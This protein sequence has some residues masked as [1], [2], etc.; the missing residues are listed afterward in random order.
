MTHIGPV[1]PNSCQASSRS[2]LGGLLTELSNSPQLFLSP[3]GRAQLKQSANTIS[4]VTTFLTQLRS[5]LSRFENICTANKQGTLDYI[6]A[7]GDI[8]VNLADLFDSVGGSALTGENLR[9]GKAFVA[10]ITV[11]QSSVKEMLR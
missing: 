5:T 7:M 9:K 1:N 3:Q 8:M 6:N 4:A 10:Q 2:S 11:S